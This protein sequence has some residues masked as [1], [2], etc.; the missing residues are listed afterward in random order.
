MMDPMEDVSLPLRE[1][2]DLS[3]ERVKRKTMEKIH[4]GASGRRFF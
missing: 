4:G 3:K 1:R 2:D